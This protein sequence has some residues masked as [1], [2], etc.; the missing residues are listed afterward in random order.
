MGCL[1]YIRDALISF[2]RLV[3]RMSARRMLVIA[4]SVIYNIVFFV[5]KIDYY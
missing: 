1:F 2:L 4:L 3:H 5:K